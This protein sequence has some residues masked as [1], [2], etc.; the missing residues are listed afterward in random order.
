MKLLTK[1]QV[2][3]K[4]GFSRAHV[5]RLTHDEKYA[6]LG[7]PKPTHV[8]FKV[9]WSEAEVDEWIEAQ[10]AKRDRS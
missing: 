2:C 1:K 3:E 10:L 7:F 4:I 9:L 5:D 8:G 6:H